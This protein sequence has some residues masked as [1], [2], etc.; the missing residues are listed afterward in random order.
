MFGVQVVVVQ[1][2]PASAADA[3]QVCTGTFVVLLV[4]HVVTRYGMGAVPNAVPA[5]QVCTG[6]LVVTL[7]VLQVVVV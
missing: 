7:A 2:L 6:T 1:L 5:V 3:V 4:E